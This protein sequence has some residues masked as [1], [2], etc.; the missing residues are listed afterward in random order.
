MT[1]G[2]VWVVPG[3]LPAKVMVAPNSPS[4]RAQASTAPAT[5]A[6]RTAG[7]VTRRK[8]YQRDAPE[9]AGG[10]LEAGI[11]LAQ[12]GLDGEDQEGHRH[13]RLRQHHRRRW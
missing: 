8:A 3:K 4:A 10:V 12:G 5:S 2:R 13:E 7:M 9:R 1:S 11:H 6:G